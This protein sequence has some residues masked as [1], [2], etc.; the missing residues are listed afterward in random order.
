MLI[1]E[2]PLDL[3]IQRAT[4]NWMEMENHLRRM[5]HRVLKPVVERAHLD[6]QTIVS[7]ESQMQKIM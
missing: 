2:K 3:D 5:L 4:G 1:E 7:N 6:R